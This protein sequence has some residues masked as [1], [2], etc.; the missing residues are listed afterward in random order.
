MSWVTFNK[1]VEML[2]LRIETNFKAA[3]A[4]LDIITLLQT[5]DLRR[6]LRHLER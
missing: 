6:I 3:R 5:Y 4:L 1:N 2:F